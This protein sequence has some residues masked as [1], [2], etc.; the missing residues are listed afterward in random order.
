M[1]L[2]RNKPAVTYLTEEQ[3]RMFHDREKRSAIITL[4]MIPYY[5]DGGINALLLRAKDNSLLWSLYSPDLDMR[6]GED[7]RQCSYRDEGERKRVLSHE[8]ER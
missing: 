4:A 8:V 3:Y 6:T 1:N 2:S 5:E 7:Y